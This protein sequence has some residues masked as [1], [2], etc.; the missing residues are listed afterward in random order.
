MRCDSLITTSKGTFIK[1]AKG[2]VESCVP[3][4][5]GQV[6][7]RKRCVTLGDDGDDGH[8]TFCNNRCKNTQHKQNF[9]LQLATRIG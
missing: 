2:I 4:E 1:I 8:G 6:N 5:L 7:V 9:I 3:V